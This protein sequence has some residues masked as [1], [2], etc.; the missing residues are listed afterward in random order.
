MKSVGGI[1]F[2]GL[3][4]GPIQGIQKDGDIQPG[5]I[6]APFVGLKEVK[7][8]K[9]VSAG[10]LN[11]ELPILKR[12]AQFLQEIGHA[13]HESLIAGEDLPENLIFF[14]D[15][16]INATCLKIDLQGLG[17]HGGLSWEPGGNGPGTHPGL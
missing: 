13:L 14:T 16:D 3:V 2:D 17:T 15:N 7:I 8:I 6:T 9:G 11:D 1:P 10:F 4:L 12:M 5:R